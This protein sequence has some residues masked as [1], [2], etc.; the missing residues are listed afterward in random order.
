MTTVM[1]PAKASCAEEVFRYDAHADALACA[2]C[3]PS[4]ARPHALV[5]H[6]SG[7]GP[8][9]KEFDPDG[10]WDGRYVAALLPEA[11]G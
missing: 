2:S 4:G 5:P 9:G 8:L 11:S 3:D 10:L 7:A 6:F 1:R